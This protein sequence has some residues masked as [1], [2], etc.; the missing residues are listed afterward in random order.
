MGYF[1]LLFLIVPLLVLSFA[2]QQYVDYV[3]FKWNHVENSVKL[4]GMQAAQ[5]ISKD[6]GLGVQLTMINK[7]L[8]DHYVPESHTVCLSIPVA[9]QPSVA[10]LAYT[11]F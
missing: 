10:A 1:Y 8:G 5:Q 11:R 6:A 9:T 3:F 4:M 7:K 2:A